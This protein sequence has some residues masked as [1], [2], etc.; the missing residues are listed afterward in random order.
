MRTMQQPAKEAEVPSEDPAATVVNEAAQR[1]LN[2]NYMTL[3]CSLSV[4]SS[5]DLNKRHPG[6]VHSYWDLVIRRHCKNFI[7]RYKQG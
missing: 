4:G 1:P 6:P 7:V 3:T 5:K 2:C